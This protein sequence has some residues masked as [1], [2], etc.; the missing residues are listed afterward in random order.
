METHDDDLL[1]LYWGKLFEH[2]N[3]HTLL[4][5]TFEKV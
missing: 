2:I 5:N 1:N 4:K 3:L